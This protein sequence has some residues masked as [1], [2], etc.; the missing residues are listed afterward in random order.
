MLWTDVTLQG[1]GDRVFP[2]W[3]KL[4]IPPPTDLYRRFSQL[5]EGFGSP[6]TELMISH[7]MHRRS[8]MTAHRPVFCAL[9][10]TH[11]LQ[12]ACLMP[13]K[14]SKIQLENMT[15]DTGLWKPSAVWLCWTLCN[16]SEHLGLFKHLR[17]HGL[18]WVSCPFILPSFL[19][20]LLQKF[21]LYVIHYF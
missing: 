3:H 4:S 12:L 14:I 21:F 6:H 7:W 18:Q 13:M 17:L 11:Y 2:S 1:T 8:S 10:M 5:F 20:N 16:S 19:Q 15:C 9:E